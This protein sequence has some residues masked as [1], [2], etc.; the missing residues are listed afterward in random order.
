[1]TS[2][3]TLVNAYLSEDAARR[4]IEVLLAAGVPEG[5]IGRLSGRRLH[6][7]RREPV[8]G[9]AGPVGPSASVGTYG[10]RPVLR[11]QGTGSYIGD[12]DRQRQGSYADADRVAIVT[13]KDRAEHT[14]VT[15]HRGARKL[16]RRTALDTDAI[17]RAV[18][19]LA[20]GQHVVLV[21]VSQLT[22]DDTAAQLEHLAR[23]A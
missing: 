23:A 14:R 18:D 1:M 20:V 19:A 21:D 3:T 12:A 8:G 11:R 13:Q 2:I 6:D 10:S 4:A 17:D 16:L 15:G 7:T 9:W 22:A 5:D